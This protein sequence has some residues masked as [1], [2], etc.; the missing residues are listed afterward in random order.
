[1][2]LVAAGVAP[3]R[4]ALV[5]SGIDP[6]E[7]R[8]AAAFP[9]DIRTQLGLPGAT[10]LVANIAALEPAK[11]HATLI[12]AV[13]HARALRPELHWVIAGGG[14]LRR[15][16]AADAR[17]LKLTDRIHFIGWTDHPEALLRESDVVVMSSREE[18]LGTVVLT[19]SRWANRSSH[20]RRRPPRNR[21]RAVA[22]R[23][24]GR[25]SPGGEGVASAG[26]PF[27]LPFPSQYTALAMARGVLTLYRSLT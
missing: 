20:Q 19:R 6:D 10:P 24:G 12:R 17:R 22:C 15:A 14:P 7:V 18:G 11:D 9:L 16:L 4:I 25:P 5:P 26:S 2:A 27:P 23:S 21:P 8:R 1:M 3:A 13:A